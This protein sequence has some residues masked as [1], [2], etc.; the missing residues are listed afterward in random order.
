MLQYEADLK[1]RGYVG[2][3]IPSKSQIN[4]NSVEDLD[5]FHEEI[6]GV[7]LLLRVWAEHV[8][9]NDLSQETQ[10]QWEGDLALLVDTSHPMIRPELERALEQARKILQ[11]RGSF[12]IQVDFGPAIDQWLKIAYPR[13]CCTL[14][15]IRNHKA[16]LFITN[17][18]KPKNCFD[19]TAIWWLLLGPCWLVSAPC[20]KL[21]RN[22]KCVDIKICPDIAVV[23]RTVLPNGKIVEVTRCVRISSFER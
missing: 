8:I 9:Q 20:Y 12:C 7:P 21:Y 3:D 13:P 1:M 22:F 4:I 19:C 14:G 5:C 16:L 23:R 2:D 18:D 11:S 17:Y 10:V 6:L 15:S